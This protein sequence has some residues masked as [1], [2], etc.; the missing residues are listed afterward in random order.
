MYRRLE[1]QVNRIYYRLYSRKK[2]AREDKSRLR[3]VFLAIRKEYNKIYRR[4]VYKY[5]DTK[6]RNVIASL[7]DFAP[8]EHKLYSM[9]ERISNLLHK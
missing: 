1:Q 9:Q 2:L 5:T 3:K 8:R 4:Y 6:G 7:D